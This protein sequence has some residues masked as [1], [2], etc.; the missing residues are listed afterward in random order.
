MAVR[1]A[2]AEAGDEGEPARAGVLH[3][4][5]SWHDPN[6][7]RDIA[8]VWAEGFMAAATRMR[9]SEANEVANL[10]LRQFTATEEALHQ[11]EDDLVAFR[12]SA[13]LALAKQTVELLRSR[14]RDE[15]SRVLRLE[16]E[17]QVKE[18][19]LATLEGEIAA[20]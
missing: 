13:Q 2:A 1:L 10:I 8:N 14:M 12:E 11:A 6:Q 9:R 3:M 19:R 20:L 5:V 17:L 16:Y 15:Q 7:A 4:D 18:D